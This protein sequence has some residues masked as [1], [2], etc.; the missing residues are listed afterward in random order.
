MMNEND[1][2]AFREEKSTIRP[3]VSVCISVYNGEDHL[4]KCLDSVI[5]QDISSMEIV[6]V[7]DGST[8]GTSE[9]MHE[10]QNRFPEIRIIE[11]ENKGLAQGRWTGVKNSDGKYVTFLDA[12]DYLLE[13]AYKTILQFMENNEADIYEFQTIREGYYSR[14]PYSGIMEAGQV[15]T[16]YFN[17]AEIPVNYWLRWFKRELF[18]ESVFPVGISL[19]EDVYG[20]PCLLNRADTIAYIGKPLH[21]HIKTPVS[22]M[23]T[24]YEKK[25]TREY[26][27]KQKILL[28]AIPHIIKNIG[29]NVIDTEYKEAFSH[30]VARKYRNFVFLD[31]KG[32][33]YNEKLDAII[34]TL[35]LKIS[36][37]ELER[38]IAQHIRLQSKLDCVIHLLGLHDGYRLYDLKKRLSHSPLRGL[39]NRTRRLSR[40]MRYKVDM[41]SHPEQTKCLCPCC[42]MKFREFKEGPFLN[43]PDRYD[44]KRYINIDQSVLCPFCGSMPRHR[45]LAAWCEKHTEL[46]RSSTIL[47]FAPEPNMMLWMKRNRVKCTT[48]DLFQKADLALDIQKTGLPD[49]SYDLIIANHV[50]EHVDDFREALKEI[51]RI[52][53]PDGLFICSF[54]MDPKVEILDEDESIKT[55]EMRLSRYGQNDHKR[56]FGLKADHLLADAG[57]SVTVIKGEDYPNEILPVVGPAD[58]DMNR[59]FCCRKSGMDRMES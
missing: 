21:V 50:M 51:H 55:D 54:P 6:L 53:R 22:I 34:E 26:F 17:G 24:L 15:L 28:R 1:N 8:D 39:R 18:S 14:S 19:H 13:G 35:G 47:Y 10:Y 49:E 5:S 16:D 2:L 40:R 57:F 41:V 36:R 30:Y 52:L 48:A 3:L 37:R 56:L 58:Y 7:N 32:I 23:N 27:E 44:P 43:R 59:L 20:F 42:G 45:I 33:S 12:D 46:L 29:Q 9:I 11:Q 38:Y 4:R 25:N 31:V